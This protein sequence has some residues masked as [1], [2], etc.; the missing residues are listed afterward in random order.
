MNRIQ[1]YLEQLNEGNA[2]AGAK[3][4]GELEGAKNATIKPLDTDVEGVEDPEEPEH[5]QGVSEQN[6]EGVKYNTM[7]KD[8][9]FERLYKQAIN[10]DFD[11]VAGGMGG[12]DEFGGGDEF[13]GDMGGDDEFGDD[14]GDID[15]D[16]SHI[17]K[18]REVIDLLQ[19]ALDMLS[20]FEG[21]EEEEYDEFEDGGDDEF[22]DGGGGFGDDMGGDEPVTEE[23][24]HTQFGK[25]KTV[26]HALV[27]REKFNKGQDKKGNMLVKGA[28]PSVAKGKATVPPGQKA[29][30]KLSSFSDAGGKKMQGK[31]NMKVPGRASNTGKFAFE[32]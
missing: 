28:N 29:D 24:A 4:P 15:S 9:V 23:E 32:G 14:A 3:A 26:G 27:N 11:D 19:Q 12:D 2:V 21:E 18:V 1:S 30:G 20:S 5:L 10:E 8:N 22:G 31:G 13:G 17:G 16:P 25:A 7:S 6:K